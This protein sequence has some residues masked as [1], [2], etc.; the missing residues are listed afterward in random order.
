MSIDW[1]SNDEYY[2]FCAAPSGRAQ[3]FDY[4]TVMFFLV[5]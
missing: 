2:V 3:K 4:D 5:I 1:P